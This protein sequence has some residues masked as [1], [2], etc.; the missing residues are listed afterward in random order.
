MTLNHQNNI[1]IKLFSQNYTETRYYTRY[2]WF[3]LFKNQ[4][5]IHSTIKLTFDLEN[6]L[7]SL[8][9]YQKRTLLSKSHTNNVLH[10]FLFAFA[11]YFFVILPFK[12]TYWPW[13]WPREWPWIIKI[14]H[15]HSFDLWPWITAAILR[16][17]SGGNVYT[18]QIQ[19]REGM[20][21]QFI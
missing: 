3:Y 1:R 19:E 11:K 7:E 21:F 6:E 9:E 8:K 15:F 16:K 17:P 12:L 18:Q 20:D 4:I 14:S 13:K 2:Y 5:F 10:V